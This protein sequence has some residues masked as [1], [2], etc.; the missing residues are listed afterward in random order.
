MVL[1]IKVAHIDLDLDLI[2]VSKYD[3]SIVTINFLYV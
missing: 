1:N 3:R 2:I